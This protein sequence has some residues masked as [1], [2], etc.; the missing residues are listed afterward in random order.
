M[1]VKVPTITDLN[2]TQREVVK[3]EPY[4]SPMFVNGPPGSGKTHVAILRLQVLLNNG[5]TNVLFLLYNHSMYGFLRTVF[6][7]MGL[8][9]NVEIS[10]KDI[11]LI[12]LAARKGNRDYGYGSDYA[13]S[14]NAKLNFLLGCS[15]HERYDVIVIDECQDFS[16]T[17]IKVLQRMTQKIIA[18]GD[19]DQNVYQSRPSPLFSNLPSRK[20]KTIYRFGKN[21]AL[22]A[23]PFSKSKESLADKVSITND[24]N[25][26]RVKAGSDAD[27]ISKIARIVESKRYTDQTIAILSL[28]NNQLRNLESGLKGK[29]INVF[30]AQ[31]NAEFRDYDFDSG[32]PVLITPFSAKGMEFDVVILYG[33]NDMLGYSSWASLQKEIIYV[34]LTRTSNELYLIQQSDTHYLLK[35]LPQWVDIDTGNTPGVKRFSDG[36]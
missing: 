9:T 10:T 21:V 15:F 3:Y 35:N 24:T 20:L 28:T 13:T 33:Y 32:R 8:A 5:Y 26:F 30:Y 31:K 34:S 36:F 16:D 18:V 23:Q 25:V 4:D 14:Y 7:K 12:N 17:E 2:S 22:I 27:G 6:R 11:F 19:L 29:G 1:P